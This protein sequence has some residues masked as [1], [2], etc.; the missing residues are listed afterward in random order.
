MQSDN[1]VDFQKELK[2]LCEAYD[3][4][5]TPEI[6]DAYWS[7][8]SKMS[9]R[10][11]KIASQIA[12][13]KSGT[14]D[15][16][17]LPMP[18]RFWSLRDEAARRE[19]VD[20]PNAAQISS[21]GHALKRPQHLITLRHMA[22]ESAINETMPRFKGFIVGPNHIPTAYQAEY[23]KKWSDWNREYGSRHPEFWWPRARELMMQWGEK[24][25][26]D[27]LALIQ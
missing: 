14:E 22:I 20:R 23:T 15:F 10:D 5:Y 3:R 4:K 25:P 7:G 24:Q 17:R 27:V 2:S 16:K 11:F 18:G 19:Q 26:D 21:H 9:I 6:E 13:E 1:W 8:L 12:R